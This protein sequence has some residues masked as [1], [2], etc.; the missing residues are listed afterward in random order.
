MKN[1]LGGIIT[2][3]LLGLAWPMSPLTPLLFMAWVPLLLVEQTYRERPMPFWLNY[4]SFVIWNAFVSW[5]VYFA[6]AGGS[7]LAILENALVMALIFQ[8]AHFL[9]RQLYRFK[10]GSFLV[11]AQIPFLLVWL[12]F[13]YL[14]HDWD[15]S[16]PWLTLGNGLANHTHW[17]QWYE[18][19]GVLGGSCW[20]LMVNL[21]LLQVIN[22]R[23]IVK[24]L[25]YIVPAIVCPIGLSYFIFNHVRPTSNKGICNVAIV[26]PNIDPYNEKFNGD[27]TNQLR[28]MLEQAKFIVDTSTELLVFPETALTENLLE[29]NLEASQSIPLLR[30]FLAHYPNLTILTGASTARI[31]EPF[32]VHGS[33]AQKLPNSNNYFENYNTALSIHGN[34]PIGIYHKSKLVPGVELMPFPSL[35][36]PL[37]SL[38]LNLGG[39]MGSLGTQKERLNFTH[40]RGFPFAPI[41]CYESIYGDFVSQ[42]AKEGAALLCIITNDG[43]WS[44]TPGYKQHLIYGRLRAIETRKTIVRS[45]NTGISAF[46]NEK[47]EILQQTNW[48]KAQVIK[49]QVKLNNDTTLYVR[50][51]DWI[52][53]LATALT[54]LIFVILLAFKTKTLVNFKS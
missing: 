43:W 39:T 5:W 51:G 31:F 21:L 28:K 49:A 37:E 1:A 40:S 9:N 46:I 27:Y 34:E 29:N 42:Y 2:G 53:K 6:S 41:I 19:T 3:L 25:L 38:A 7:L 45:A 23:K 24:G 4:F 36:K 13:E 54:G 30:Q 20:I 44:D 16:Y 8:L 52:G 14:H 12:S 10:M 48:W 11:K 18:Y 17:I 15:L 33:T 47:G 32:E 50:F 22:Q 35:L 26:Q